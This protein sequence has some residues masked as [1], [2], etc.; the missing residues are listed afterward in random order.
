MLARIAIPAVLSIVSKFFMA[1]IS[2]A[3]LPSGNSD[4]CQGVERIHTL[5]VGW[6]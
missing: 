5:L 3:V 6:E 2:A 4:V 1:G